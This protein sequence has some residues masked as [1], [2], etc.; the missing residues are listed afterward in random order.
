[1]RLCLNPTPATTPAI[2][3][4]LKA[5]G[6]YVIDLDDYERV[7]LGR[8]MFLAAFAELT[9]ETFMDLSYI[10]RA[11]CCLD[12]IVDPN[13][14]SCLRLVTDL[15]YNGTRLNGIRIERAIP[16]RLQHGQLL[17]VLPWKLGYIVDDDETDSEFLPMPEMAD[18]EQAN[19]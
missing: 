8:E 16:Y 10:S 17:E 6:L 4:A 2:V 19:T 7:I 5:A 3:S 12:R 13:A 15:S 9:Q 11:H 14:S 1:M 18:V